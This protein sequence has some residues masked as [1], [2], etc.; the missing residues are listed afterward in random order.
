LQSCQQGFLTGSYLK[1]LA[2]AEI[3]SSSKTQFKKP[4]VVKEAADYSINHNATDAAHPELLKML[5]A[6]RT[7]QAMEEGVAHYRII[8]QQVLVQIANT[9]ANTPAALLKIKGLGESTVEKYGKRLIAMVLE[10]CDTC[11]IDPEQ[12]QSLQTASDENDSIKAGSIEAR[13]IKMDTKKITYELYLQGNSIK[14]IAKKR[15]FVTSTIEVHIA[16]YI[17]LGEL[18][19]NDFVNE[20]K[21][22]LIE[23]AF[24]DKG[25]ES[26]GVVKE[27][28]GES[29]SYGEIRMVLESLA[30]E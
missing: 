18:N 3:D 5:K 25:K 16:H 17:K 21:V 29:F 9:L 11:Q 28:L 6:W 2:L 10:Y 1:A 12:I 19:I 27:H 20:E 13:P 14:Q 15:G 4:Q 7:E 30:G 23:K 26:L 8:H 24:D 22:A